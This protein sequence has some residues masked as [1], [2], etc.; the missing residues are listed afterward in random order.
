MHIQRVRLFLC[1]LIAS[2]AIGQSRPKA[3]FY[4]T[5]SSASIQ[6]FLQH[7]DKIDLLVPTWYS[8]DDAGL[9][10]GGP[11]ELVL[12]PARQHHVPVMPII[13]NASIAPKTSFSQGT[14]I[15]LLRMP[16]LAPI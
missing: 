7:A 4:M 1:V 6:S 9:V 13:I 11:D 15:N 2:T 5:E 8:V 12:Q 16:R 14:F 10:W 3:L